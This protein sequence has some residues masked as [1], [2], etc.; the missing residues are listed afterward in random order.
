MATKT[1]QNRKPLSSGAKGVICLAVLLVITLCASFLSI[2]GMNLDAEGV[3]V[4]LP[5]VPV[6]SANWPA[7]LPVNLSLGG[8]TY[9]EYTYKPNDDAPADALDAS[10]KTIR[11]RLAQMGETDAAVSVKDEAVR[12]EL[13]KMDESRLATLRNMAT[14]G[15]QFEYAL[16]SVHDVHFQP[17][18]S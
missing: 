12:I 15:G 9:V 4:L 13:R 7:S 10:V 2:A 8:G 17:Y 14:M 1:T 18:Y 3:N 6:S 11:D 16:L 5:W